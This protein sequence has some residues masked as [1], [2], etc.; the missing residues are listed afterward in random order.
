MAKKIILIDFDT[1]I[2]E[3]KNGKPEALRAET[4]EAIAEL[5]AAGYQ[6]HVCSR[7]I[8]DVEVINAFLKEHKI[9]CDKVVEIPAFDIFLSRDAISGSDR[10]KWTLENIV[11]HKPEQKKDVRKEMHDAM[12]RYRKMASRDESVVCGY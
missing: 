7:T 8:D 4:A 1:A 2:A 5:R 11:M 6:V 3:V 10:W 12:Q 9:N